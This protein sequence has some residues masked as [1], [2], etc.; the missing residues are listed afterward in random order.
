[1]RRLT[2]LLLALLFVNVA[3]VALTVYLTRPTCTCVLGGDYTMTD[4]PADCAV[5]GKVVE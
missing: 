3:A 5:H 1:M 4:D 2:R